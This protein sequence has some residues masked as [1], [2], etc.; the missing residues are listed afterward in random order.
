MDVDAIQVVL[1]PILLVVLLILLMPPDCTVKTE[2]VMTGQ[3]YCQESGAIAE[4]PCMF[5]VQLHSLR[6]AVSCAIRKVV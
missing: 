3:Q 6:R 1:V 4:S 2:S 5:R